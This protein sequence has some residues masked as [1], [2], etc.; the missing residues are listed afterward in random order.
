MRLTQR[1]EDGDRSVNRTLRMLVTGLMRT[2]TWPSDLEITVAVYLVPAWMTS[3]TRNTLELH[4]G[5][6]RA[7]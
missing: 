2:R 3:H 1:S 4:D 7:V 5:A 6:E